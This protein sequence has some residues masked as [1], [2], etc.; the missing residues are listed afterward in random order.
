MDASKNPRAPIRELLEMINHEILSLK[1]TTRQ[2]LE[3]YENNFTASKSKNELHREN[4]LRSQHQEEMKRLQSAMKQHKKDYNLLKKHTANLEKDLKEEQ[5]RFRRLLFSKTVGLARTQ[6]VKKKPAAHFG[7]THPALA[8]GGTIA[9]VQAKRVEQATLLAAVEARGPLMA[10]DAGNPVKNMTRPQGGSAALSQ[11]PLLEGFSEPDHHGGFSQESVRALNT[12]FATAATD[13]AAV[14]DVDAVDDGAVAGAV[15]DV[16]PA[17][18]NFTSSGDARGAIEDP[19]YLDYSTVVDSNHGTDKNETRQTKLEHFGGFGPSGES[20]GVDFGWETDQLPRGDV[21]SGHRQ[22]YFPPQTAAFVSASIAKT[23]IADDGRRRAREKQSNKNGKSSNN[24]NRQSGASGSSFSLSRTSQDSMLSLRN[25]RAQSANTY[26]RSRET[27]LNGVGHDG[28]AAPQAHTAGRAIGGR[29]QPQPA[30]YEVDTGFGDGS[31]SL[32]GGK[33]PFGDFRGRGLPSRSAGFR[34]TSQWATPTGM[35]GSAKALLKSVSTPNL[36]GTLAV[37]AM[38]PPAQPVPAG[39]CTPPMSPPPG[40]TTNS[41]MAMM[42]AGS[43][44][45]GG[46]PS[47]PQSRSAGGRTDNMHYSRKGFPTSTPNSKPLGLDLD[48]PVAVPVMNSL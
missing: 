39:D 33:S 44:H 28:H 29:M 10:K 43:V 18:A 7:T 38:H 34:K 5:E 9:M 25:P 21:H 42:W 37:S 30:V 23:A 2:V 26:G 19:G 12:T 11:P 22:G 40:H 1:T 36:H 20:G 3:V 27:S 4:A 24:A 35:Q 47:R 16:A 41:L 45:P 15:A 31:L 14:D 48:Q 13:A 6:S 8:T 46:G 32:L 17:N